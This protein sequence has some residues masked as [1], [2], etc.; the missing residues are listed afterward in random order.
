MKFCNDAVQ[1]RSMGT[2]SKS[3]I[4]TKFNSDLLVQRDISV[5]I[6]IQIQSAAADRQ[7]W[8]LH[9]ILG[10]VVMVSLYSRS[11]SVAQCFHE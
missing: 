3:G 11:V 8:E 4:L 6:I 5:K 10:S 7:I 9:N 1:L 2:Q